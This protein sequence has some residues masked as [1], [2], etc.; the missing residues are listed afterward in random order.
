MALQHDSTG[1][2]S[3]SW[4]YPGFRQSY[5]KGNVKGYLGFRFGIHGQTHY[6]WARLNVFTEWGAFTTTL[7]G[8][9]YET[10]PNKPI[11]LKKEQGPCQRMKAGK[12]NKHANP[13]PSGTTEPASL[14][15]LALGALGV[16]AWR[17]KE[18]EGR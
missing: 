5:G 3:G 13:A 7:L 8:Y 2:D 14:G 18:Q 4:L 9:A 10:I 12:E 1:V 6:G 15:H 17:R 16:P 11:I